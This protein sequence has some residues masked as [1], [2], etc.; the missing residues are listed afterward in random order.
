VRALASENPRR[1]AI[2]LS[3]MPR[4]AS[5]WARVRRRSSTISPVYAKLEGLA[6]VLV[7][8]GEVEI[9]RDDILG[10]AKRLEAAGVDVKTH[11]AKDM[12][13]NPPVF[14]AYHP[15]GVAALEEA[16]SFVRV[17]AA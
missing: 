7:I 11:V 13:H 10:L 15:S 8:V 12:P 2:S 1:K 6:P 5:A 16:A 3:L 9:P 17:S 14:A 4:R